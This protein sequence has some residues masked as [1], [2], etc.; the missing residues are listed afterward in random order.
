MKIGLTLFSF[1]FCSLTTGFASAQPALSDA[2]SLG[3]ISIANSSQVEAALVAVDRAQREAVLNYAKKMRDVHAASNHDVEDVEIK[4]GITRAESDDS[5]SLKQKSDSM[6]AALKLANN[7]DFEKL[8]IDDQVVLHEEMVAKIDQTLLPSAQNPDVKSFLVDL[9][10][11]FA[12]H[13]AEARAIQ[14]SLNAPANP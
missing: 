8:Y 3:V 5:R 11:M 4:V 7:N 6:V 13:G 14:A 12:D 9:R 1:L 2:Q 10:A